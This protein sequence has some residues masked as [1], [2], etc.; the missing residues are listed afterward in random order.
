[1]SSHWISDL[2]GTLKNAFRIA[3]ATID[4]S[5]C[6]NLNTPLRLTNNGIRLGDANCIDWN[7]QTGLFISKVA[8]DTLNLV[9]TSNG[10]QIKVGNQPN[11]HINSLVDTVGGFRITGGTG[12]ATDPTYTFNGN[13]TGTGIFLKVNQDAG[14]TKLGIVTQPSGTSTGRSVVDISLGTVDFLHGSADAISPILNFLKSRGTSNSPTVISSGDSLGRLSGKGYVGSTGLFVE[15]CA[16]ELDTTS[17]ITPTDDAAGLSGE[18]AFHT[19]VTGAGLVE[20]IR[21]ARG[22]SLTCT[23]FIKA[24]AYQPTPLAVTFSATPNFNVSLGDPLT[25]TLTGNVTG[26]TFSGGVD[27]QKITIR[28]RQDATGG[29]TFAFDSSFVRFGTDITGITLSTGANK[30][31]YI[32]LV[33]HASDAKYD[34][35]A[36]TK[37]F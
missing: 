26:A 36:F 8:D 34:I 17:A 23:S 3:K 35:V 7:S 31:D 25:M 6:T 1:M 30:T 20:V 27:G 9:G 19:R 13:N 10:F 5:A 21:I 29:R 37:G 18:I 16:I 14:A 11:N 24:K 32:G 33:Y 15:A 28:L 2:V 4:S 22:G 12:Q